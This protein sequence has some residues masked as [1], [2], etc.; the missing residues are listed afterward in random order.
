[1]YVKN[2]FIAVLIKAPADRQIGSHQG[3]QATHV[4]YACILVRSVIAEFR[5]RNVSFFFIS[6]HFQRFRIRVN[7]ICIGK[8]FAI[9]KKYRLQFYA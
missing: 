7:N 5:F 1:M 9:T 3:N 4:W 6:Y 2:G 8:L